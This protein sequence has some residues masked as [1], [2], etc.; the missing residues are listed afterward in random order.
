M[1]QSILF[2]SE[3]YLVITGNETINRNH[4][5]SSNDLRIRDRISE[6]DEEHKSQNASGEAT[7]NNGGVY[8][9]V[10]TIHNHFFDSIKLMIL[11]FLLK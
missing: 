2:R 10:Y 3:P 11:Y 6:D 4:R 7:Q 9:A 1:I 5:L 8:I